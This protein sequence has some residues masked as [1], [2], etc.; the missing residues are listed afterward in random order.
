MES[1]DEF[2]KKKFPVEEHEIDGLSSK[3]VGYLLKYV[4]LYF[5]NLRVQVGDTELSSSDV[6]EYEIIPYIES[7]IK[8][9]CVYRE[10]E[11]RYIIMKTTKASY[12][13]FE[14]QEE[15]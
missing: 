1:L 15:K 8:E 9:T 2:L 13:K 14:E 5:C 11:D 6:M 12:E 7:M 4:T 3:A 10:L